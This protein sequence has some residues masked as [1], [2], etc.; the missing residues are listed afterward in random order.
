[1]RTEGV[2]FAVSSALGAGFVMPTVGAI[3]Y[4][5]NERYRGSEASPPL[6][7]AL[8]TNVCSSEEV[9]G[10]LPTIG[11]GWVARKNTVRSFNVVEIQQVSPLLHLVVSNTTV[12]GGSVA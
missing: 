7:T 3:V 5:K 10:L 12:G 6:S 8:M 2:T 9:G 1:M 4:E 11:S